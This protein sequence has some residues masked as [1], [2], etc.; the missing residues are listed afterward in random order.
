[1]S[2]LLKQYKGDL[3]NFN[4]L[5]DELQNVIEELEMVNR[6]K[7]TKEFAEDILQEIKNIRMSIMA[8]TD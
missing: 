5:K 3:S 6:L 2:D 1:M 8:I 4:C 7:V